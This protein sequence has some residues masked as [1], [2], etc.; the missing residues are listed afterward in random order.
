MQFRTPAMR[1]TVLLLASIACIFFS[2]LQIILHVVIPN[3]LVFLIT[4]MFQGFSTSFLVVYIP[5]WLSEIAQSY[6]QQRG[7]LLVLFQLGITL[8]IFFNVLSCSF[9]P[10]PGEPTMGGEF[11]FYF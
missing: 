6:K 2:A 4:N 7:Y 9:M 11:G 1:E 3:Y 8:G 10:M 5:V